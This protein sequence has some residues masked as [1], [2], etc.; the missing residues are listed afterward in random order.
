M[1][2]L[3]KYLKS[4][5]KIHPE[6]YEYQLNFDGCSRG[7]PG[8]AG[9]GTVL[10]KDGVE[11]W[12]NNLFIGEN[13]TNNQ[14]EYAGLILGLTEANVR[15]IKKLKV[16]GDSLLIINQLKGVYECKSSNL[17][18]LYDKALML[19]NLFEK[20]EFCHVFR[21]NNK[22]ADELSNIA[23]DNYLKSNK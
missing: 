5:A 18:I 13:C 3:N 2:T 7:N 4:S 17:Q 15:S 23:V 10:Y 14:A 16:E 21:H 19:S 9:A 12:S 22:R 1:T 8:L 20:I 6:Y 11:I